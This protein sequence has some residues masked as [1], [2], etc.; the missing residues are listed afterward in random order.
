[1]VSHDYCKK[2]CFTI[3]ELD[4]NT[5]SDVISHTIAVEV[6]L[7]KICFLYVLCLHIYSP[8]P[9]GPNRTM[10]LFSSLMLVWRES[11]TSPPLFSW[12]GC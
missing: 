7:N 10:L 12:A 11:R 3:N 4:I 2:K 1:M 5:S 9:V 8:D 6:L